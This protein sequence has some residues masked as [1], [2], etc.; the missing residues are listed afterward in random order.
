[1]AHKGTVY[2][3]EHRPIIDQALWDKVHTILA[4]SPRLC[5]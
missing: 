4:D 2:P 5:L 3:D 1:V